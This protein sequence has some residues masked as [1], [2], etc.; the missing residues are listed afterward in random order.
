[1][2]RT[3]RLRARGY[4]RQMVSAADPSAADSTLLLFTGSYPFRIAVEDSFIKPELPYLREVFGRVVLVPSRCEGDRSEV[5]ERVQVDES[6][7]RQMKEASARGLVVRGLRSRLTRQDVWEHPTLLVQPKAIRLLIASSAR[8]EVARRWLLEFLARSDQ[9]IDAHVAYSFWCN[10]I[11]TGLALAKLDAPKLIAISRAHGVDLY[12]QRHSPSYL[13][14]RSF[15]YRLLDGVFPDSEL[16][17]QYLTTT[18]PF[19]AS[20]SAVARMGVDDPGFASHPSP[21]GQLSVVS[22]SFVVPVKRVDLIAKAVASAARARPDLH[23]EWH[24]FGE[25]PLLS[26]VERLAQSILPT[27][28]TARFPGYPGIDALMDFYR[29]HPID[30]FVNSSSSE[31]TPVA[32]MEAISCE[33]P[34]VATAVGGN[35]EIVSEANGVLLPPDASEEQIGAALLMLGADRGLNA[36]RRIGSRAV[37]RRKYNASVNYREF[38]RKLSN[39][40][41]A[42]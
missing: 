17:T 6:L 23:V 39:L 30:V 15:T 33:L 31:G 32:V 38:A 36:A 20:K 28:A 22:C 42:V 34:V 10:H 21:P 9:S 5:P 11:A 16:G 13:P 24:H 29:V 3:S 19:A 25:G 12:P 18:Y 41:A 7:A 14:S 27:N 1:M 8:A 40:R 2:G 37:W 35:S 4:L 26:Y